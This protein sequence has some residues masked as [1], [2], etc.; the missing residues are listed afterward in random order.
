MQ[1]SIYS[2]KYQKLRGWLKAERQQTPG[3]S[4]RALA[5]KLGVH[6]SI[7]GKIE[8][9][10]RKLDVVE[11]VEYCEALGV[12]PH[13]GIRCIQSVKIKKG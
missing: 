4:L 5:E 6:H 3:L 8:Q 10:E 9:G 7:L 12:D 11:Y 2:A 13:E 1:R